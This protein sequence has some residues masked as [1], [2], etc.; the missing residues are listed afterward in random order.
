MSG[1][2]WNWT[3]GVGVGPFKFGTSIDDYKMDFDLELVIPEGTDVTGWGGYEVD[4][5]DMTISTEE[6]KIESIQ[7][8]GYFRYKNKNLIGM[9]EEEFVAHMG[10]HPY[11][12][13]VG[14]EYDNGVVETPFEYDD[15]ALIVWTADGKVVSASASEIV[16]D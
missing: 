16:E 15:L 7:C 9:S 1:S 10:E 3:P 5:L 2:E 6:G 12:I 11:E 13:G 8:E 4:G 14:V